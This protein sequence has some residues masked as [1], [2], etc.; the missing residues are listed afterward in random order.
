MS[1]P[2]TP[3][4]L[5]DDAQLVLLG[6]CGDAVFPGQASLDAWPDAIFELLD[7]GLIELQGTFAQA[8]IVPTEAGRRHAVK[9][10]ASKGES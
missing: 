5:S 6:L 4:R 8:R 3:I 2:G 10:A 9:L 1:V 7:L